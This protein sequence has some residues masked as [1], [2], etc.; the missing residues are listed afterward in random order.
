MNTR[1]YK[2]F[3]AGEYYHV[4]NRGDNR[5]NIFLDEQDY[6]NFLKR[7]KL[8]LGIPTISTLRIKPFPIESFTVLAYCLMPNHFHILIKQNTD[9]SIGELIRKAVTSYVKY[10]NARYKRVGNLFQDIFKTKLIDSDA[11][12]SYLSAYI[13][14][15]PP[16]PLV[17]PYS[18]FPEYL[19]IRQGKICNPKFLLDYFQGD[20]NKYKEF[21][22][23][24]TQK[25]HSKIKHL[26][27]EED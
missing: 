4:Y 20:R 13:H 10:F 1:D 5:E 19:G 21:V 8:A 25:M 11:Y 14:N 12:L 7:L 3:R 15:N 22:I 2:L 24:Y 18:S 6:V 26:E 17:Y 16:E 27:F 9:L 23:G